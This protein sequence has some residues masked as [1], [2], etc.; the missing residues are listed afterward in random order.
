MTQT[1]AGTMTAHTAMTG[2]G[3]FGETIRTINGAQECKA[4]IP[5]RSNRDQPVPEFTQRLGVTVGSN[6][7]C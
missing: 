2:G 5:A 4:A 6:T 7:G 1:G 3:G